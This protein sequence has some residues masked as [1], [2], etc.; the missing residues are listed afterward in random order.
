MPRMLCPVVSGSIQLSTAFR[1][2]SHRPDEL[3]VTPGER[4]H[5]PRGP[6]TQ[7][8]LLRE[9]PRGLGVSRHPIEV[10]ACPLQLLAGGR[11]LDLVLGQPERTDDPWVPEARGRCAGTLIRI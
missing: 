6:L 8:D 4:R 11:R 5:G 1:K 7:M 9:H 10:R 3:G 2:A